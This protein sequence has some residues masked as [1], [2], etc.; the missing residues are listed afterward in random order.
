MHIKQSVQG[1]EDSLVS[2]SQH[3]DIY[4]FNQLIDHYQLVMYSVVYRIIGNTEIAADVTQD[5]FL[6]A[7]RNI[8]SYRGKA[9]FRAWL[10]RIGSNMACDH[11]RRVQRHP[12]DS[13]DHILEEGEAGIGASLVQDQEAEGNP[14]QHLMARE[15]QELLQRALQHL[16][17]DQR[18]A[19]ALCDIEGLSYE[20]IATI[21]QTTIGTVR[22]RISRGRAR[23]RDYLSHYRELLPRD[24]RLTGSE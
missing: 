10:L 9:S 20:E 24:Y 5:A 19:V 18:T 21:T 17:L 11:W 14:E 15:L 23:L 22:S 6:S 2:R 3:G 4:A 13:L 7:F 8:R 16:P 1:N 12:V